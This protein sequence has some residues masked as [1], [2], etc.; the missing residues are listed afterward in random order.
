MFM[1]GDLVECIGSHG[2]GPEVTAVIGTLV[3]PWT[4]DEWWV[5]LVD[6]ELISWPESQMGFL[7]RAE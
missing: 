3:G 6:D 7:E 2:V 5:V 4:V 1:K